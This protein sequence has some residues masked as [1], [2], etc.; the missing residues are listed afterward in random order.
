MGIGGLQRQ[1]DQLGLDVGY[2][3]F[4]QE[5]DYPKQQLGFYSNILRGTPYS[6]TRTTIGQV[7]QPSFFQ[8][9]AGL[10]ISALGAAGS[11]GWQPFA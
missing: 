8:Q 1:M 5:R 2:E 9:A 6:E 10:G 3:T 11:L 7:P 4:L